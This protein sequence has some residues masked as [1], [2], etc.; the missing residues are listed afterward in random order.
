[1]SGDV[2]TAAPAQAVA[3]AAREMIRHRISG[4][5]VLDDAGALVGLVSEYDVI[6]KHGQTVGDVMSRGVI[7][8]TEDASAEQVAR[9][10]GLHGIRRIPVV[11][12]GRLVGIVSRSDLV[13]LFAAAHWICTAC[14]EVAR[15]FTRPERCGRCGGTT[16]RLERESLG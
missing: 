11:R 13:R 3:D 4:M 16:F 15:G 1:M 2:V 5:P 12:D 9:L 7:T 6:T 8:V 10:M 14:G